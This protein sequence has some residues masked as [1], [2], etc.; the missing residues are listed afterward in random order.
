[1]EKLLNQMELLTVLIKQKNRYELPSEQAN[2]EFRTAKQCLIREKSELERKRRQRVEDLEYKIKSIKEQLAM[3]NV[4]EAVNLAALKVELEALQGNNFIENDS[5]Q[6]LSMI[7]DFLDKF[8]RAIAM[9]ELFHNW[10]C[11]VNEEKR[12]LCSMVDGGS[13]MVN[14]SLIVQDGK[15][16]I[17]EIEGIVEFINGEPLKYDPQKDLKSWALNNATRQIASR[18]REKIKK[19]KEIQESLW[20]SQSE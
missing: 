9:Q 16:I 17:S 20:L 3:G 6:L 10:Y 11:K 15:S 7:N 1:M 4:S 5:R 13:V 8:Y 2:E 18:G 12:N 19:Y 14:A